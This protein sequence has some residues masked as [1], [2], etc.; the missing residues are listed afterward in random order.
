MRELSAGVHHWCWRRRANC[1]SIH[2]SCD[3]GR[4]PRHPT[5]IIH[6]RRRYL[7]DAECLTSDIS[8][9]C[10]ATYPRQVAD[11]PRATQTDANP[12]PR[13]PAPPCGLCKRDL[14]TCAVQQVSDEKLRFHS[15][16]AW[17]SV[18]ATLWVIKNR[19]YFIFYIRRFI[20]DKWP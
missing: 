20:C 11:H 3:K 19:H 7:A 13:A 12:T 16:T 14:Q 8:T 9:I 18:Y 17:S 2:R 15:H 6:R 10:D 1:V 5:A 4:R